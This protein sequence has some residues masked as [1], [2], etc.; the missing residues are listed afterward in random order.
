MSPPKLLSAK[1]GIQHDSIHPGH[2]GLVIVRPCS[3]RLGVSPVDA[4]RGRPIYS[5]SIVCI[6]FFSNKN[7]NNHNTNLRST[8]C[9]PKLTNI[10]R[11]ET[12]RL[13]GSNIMAILTSYTKV[14]NNGRWQMR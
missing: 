11:S 13:K 10:Q 12:L 9:Q 5:C 2:R 6:R 1:H 14:S 3:I 4:A 7:D 8:R